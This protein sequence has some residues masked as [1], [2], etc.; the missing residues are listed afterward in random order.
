MIIKGFNISK[1]LVHLAPS[2]I[3]NRSQHL[4][5]VIKINRKKKQHVIQHSLPKSWQYS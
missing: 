1:K 3:K 4:K 2:F 5:V